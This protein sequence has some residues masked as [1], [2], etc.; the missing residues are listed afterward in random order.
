MR[1]LI[2]SEI[3]T[4]V[5]ISAKKAL[6]DA[7]EDAISMCKKNALQ[8]VSSELTRIVAAI[9]V[10]IGIDFARKFLAIMLKTSDETKIIHEHTS[11]LVREPLTTGI[12]ILQIAEELSADSASEIQHR[13]ERYRD[14]LNSFDK[15]FSLAS[16][17]EKSLIH[18][19]CAMTCLRIIGATQE[20]TVHLK[21]FSEACS[22][23]IEITSKKRE[24]LELSATAQKLEADSIEESHRLG[25]GGG[26]VGM[27]VA[28]LRMRKAKLQNEA[29][30]LLERVNS[31]SDSIKVLSNARLLS[32]LIML[33]MENAERLSIQED[34]ELKSIVNRLLS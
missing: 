31:L 8:L 5:F 25:V 18:F 7:F 13:N 2:L 16:E 19:L 26:L 14:A 12:R 3:P 17:D 21:R 9:P 33:R 30:S 4:L 11:K 22:R 27:D 29:A 28:A 24:K 34:N 15:A 20:A 10:D 6:K 32:Q 1:G 23:D